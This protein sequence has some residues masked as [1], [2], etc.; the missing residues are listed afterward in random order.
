MSSLYAD[1]PGRVTASVDLNDQSQVRYN[2]HMPL[3]D[4]PD[5]INEFLRA[6]GW[7]L[8]SITDGVHHDQLWHRDDVKP[9]GLCF[10][11]FEAVAYQWYLTMSLGGIGREDV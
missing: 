8:A 3:A 5:G 4:I 1:E 2:V 10:R 6:C 7:T 9:D 11:W